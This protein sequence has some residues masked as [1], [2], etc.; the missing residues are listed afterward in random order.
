MS[1]SI[2][3]DFHTPASP[4]RVQQLDF[5]HSDDGVP[6]PPVEAN[7]AVCFAPPKALIRAHYDNRV[8]RYLTGGASAV[9]ESPA[10]ERQATST[11]WHNAPKN[12]TAVADHW[13]RAAPLSETTDLLSVAHQRCRSALSRASTAS[14]YELA[15]LSLL[16]IQSARLVKILPVATRCA[17]KEDITYQNGIVTINKKL[18]IP[19]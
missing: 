10:V 17:I 14:I 16:K 19:G 11:V 12:R 8:T 7:V 18:L 2:S 5:G 15:L 9:W 6:P 13:Q 3:L 1:S 4:D